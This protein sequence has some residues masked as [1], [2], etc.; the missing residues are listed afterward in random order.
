MIIIKYNDTGF[1]E[2]RFTEYGETLERDEE[3]RI[4]FFDDV[5][6]EF[7]N[8]DDNYEKSMIYS[9]WI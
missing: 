6:N 7:S 8:T 9:D 5:W 4:E 3:T 2:F 1:E